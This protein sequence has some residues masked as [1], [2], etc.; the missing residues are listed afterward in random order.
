MSVIIR[1]YADQVE[2]DYRTNLVVDPYTIT[3][4]YT[5]K[6]SQEY[7]TV[8][9][10]FSYPYNMMNIACF[11]IPAYAPFAAA[12]INSVKACPYIR[13]AFAGGAIAGRVSDSA[14]TEE[15]VG[16]E[17]TGVNTT[18]RKELDITSLFNSEIS[19]PGGGWYFRFSTNTA[20][21]GTVYSNGADEEYRFYIEFDVT[22]IPS[23]C[24]APTVVSVDD[25]TPTPGGPVNL[26]WSGA[27]EGDWNSIVG[28]DIYR[29]SSSSGEYF[30]YKSVSSTSTYGTTT[31]IAPD[32]PGETYYYKVKTKGSEGTDYDSALSSQYAGVTATTS[33]CVAPTV[34]SL[35]ASVSSRP[36]QLSWGGAYPGI[37][38]PITRYDVEYSDSADNSTWGSWT[39]LKTLYSTE[40]SGSYLAPINANL[41]QYRRYRVKTFGTL[42][43]YDSDWSSASESVRRSSSTASDI[44]TPKLIVYE[45]PHV[46]AG[47]EKGAYPLGIIQQYNTLIWHPRYQAIGE[48][49]L[50]VPFS[51]QANTLLKTRRLVG[52]AGHNELML[53]T[54]KQIST[55]VDGVESIEVYGK[56]LPVILAKRVMTASAQ[57]EDHPVGHIKIVLRSQPIFLE[58]YDEGESDYVPDINGDLDADGDRRFPDFHW[59]EPSFSYTGDAVFIFQPEKLMSMLDNII[60]LC[61]TGGYGFR[62]TSEYYDSSADTLTMWFEIYRGVDHTTGQDVN[63]HVIFDEVLGNVLSQSYMESIENEKTAGYATNGSIDELAASDLRLVDVMSENVY[64]AGDQT[65]INAGSNPAGIGGGSG[66]SRS[67]LGIAVTDIE[68]PTIGT[69]DEKIQSLYN[70]CKQIG[71][72][73][74]AKSP[75]ELAAEVEINPYVGKQYLTDFNLGDLI[76]YRNTRYG[77]SMDARIAEAIETYEPGQKMRLSLVLGDPMITPLNRIKQISRRRG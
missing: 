14:Q 77:I 2:N 7:M 4:S 31:V 33:N 36:V 26:S 24:T 37:G 70:S 68:E 34:L 16:E 12:T 67:E 64:S 55:D 41:G 54:S 60:S 72:N 61:V 76:T 13:T 28:Y 35:S 46:T 74:I 75:V 59:L 9:R 29:A 1:I 5:D 71:K 49:A 45:Y 47:V 22:G 21:A 25:P 44:Q 38:N 23:A 15:G 63:P 10:A 8:D 58:H 17:F 30:F 56:S 43:G 65:Y 53:I 27:A 18:G 11:R 69:T 50:S 51:A 6:T 40:A 32:A 39:A 73:E 57:N 20:E 3:H 48:F 66:M 62:V 42:E 19:N 52:K